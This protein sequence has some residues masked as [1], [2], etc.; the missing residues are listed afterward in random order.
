M[1]GELRF[2]KWLWAARFFKTRSAASHAVM[3]GKVKLND[4]RV[5]PAKLMGP[6]DR[7]AIVIGDYAWSITVRALSDRRGPASVARELYYEDESSR[8]Q[9]EASVAARRQ[10]YAVQPLAGGRPEKKQRRNLERTRGY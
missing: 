4:Q 3:G 2:D 1:D 9:R 8:E 7:L 5:K 10:G 6:G